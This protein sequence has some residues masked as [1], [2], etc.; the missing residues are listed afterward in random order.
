M[1]GLE[2]GAWAMIDRCPID[3]NVCK[4]VIELRVGDG[5]D[6]LELTATE[7]GLA[8]LVAKATE[9]L[10]AFRAAQVAGT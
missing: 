7:S 9:A 5:G 6:V 1:S 10:G 2:M 3:Y 8:N 4:D